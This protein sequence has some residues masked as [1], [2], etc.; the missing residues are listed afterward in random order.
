MHTTYSETKRHITDTLWVDESM[1]V[2]SKWDTDFGYYRLTVRT[3][4][5]ASWEMLQR[6][7]TGTEARSRISVSHGGPTIPG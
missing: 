2:D 6:G 4:E 7:M 5:M 1:E 3:D